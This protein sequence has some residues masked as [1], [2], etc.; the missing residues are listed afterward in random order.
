MCPLFSFAS[1]FSR[2][3]LGK[4]AVGASKFFFGQENVFFI[5]K[6]MDVLAMPFSDGIMER[7]QTASLVRVVFPLSHHSRHEKGC[8]VSPKSVFLYISSL[9]RFFFFSAIAR[10]VGGC[11]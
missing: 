10:F 9:S 2:G 1:V 11:P 5:I 4:A 3:P 6:M 8:S 7:G